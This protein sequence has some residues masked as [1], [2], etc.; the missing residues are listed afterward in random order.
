MI[1]NDLGHAG[2]RI[3]ALPKIEVMRVAVGQAR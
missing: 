2:I 3:E 1:A